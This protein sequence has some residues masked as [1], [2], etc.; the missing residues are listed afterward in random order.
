[1]SKP[2]VRR[3]DPYVALTKAQFRERF[4]SR[5]YDPV[6][7]Q[8]AAELEKVFEKAWDGYIAYRKS[9]RLAPAGADFAASAFELPRVCRF[10]RAKKQIPRPPPSE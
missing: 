9:P 8:V 5:F 7:E 6:F 10:I 1:M 2:P 4:F 3:Q